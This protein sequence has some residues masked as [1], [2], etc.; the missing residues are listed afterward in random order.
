M[1]ANDIRKKFLGFFATKG[2]T[3]IPSDSLVPKNDPSVLFTTA[4]MQQF[5]RQFLGHIEGY[6]RAATSQKCLRTD[7]LEQVGQTAFHH[8]F[9]EMLGN[10]SFGD[11]FKKEAIAWAW[12]F[13]TKELKIPEDKLWATIYKNDSEAEDIWIKEIKIP[14]QRLI[15]LGDKSNFWPS[16]AKTDG[17]NGPCGPC[18]EIFYDYGV[19]PQCPNTKACNPDCDCGR[20]SEVWNLVFTQFNRQEGG[21]LDPLPSKNIDTGMGLERLTAVVQGKQN[22]FDT[23]LFLP[24]ISAV[25]EKIE[26]GL[27]APLSR[28]EKNII[29]DHIRAIVFAINDG[30]IPSNKERGFV[31]KGLIN[32]STNLILSKGVTKPSIYKLVPAVMEVMQE[33]YP[34]LKEKARDITELIKKTEEAFITVRQQRVPELKAKIKTSSEKELGDLFFI[35]H[36][37]YGLPLSTI[38]GTAKQA[39]PQSR[40]E[41]IINEAI[42]TYNKKM[43]EQKKRSRAASK[44]TDDVFTNIGLDLSAHKTIFTGYEELHNTTKIAELFA[45]DKRNEQ[46]KKGD[47]VK[48]ILEHTPFC[49]EAGGQIGDTGLIEKDDNV[50][51]VFDTQKIDNA[52]L[53]LGTV[54]KGAFKVSDQV[55]A[56][57]NRGRRL[58]IMRNHTATHLL[59]AALRKVLGSHVQQQGSLVEENR[60]RFDFTHPQAVTNQQLM[61]IENFVNER[62]MRCLEVSKTDMSLEQAKKAGALAFFAEKYGQQVRVVA[63]NDCSKEL[64]GGT[65]L[66][67]TGEIGLFKIISESAIAQGIR[68]IEAK[69]GWGALELIKNNEEVLNNISKTLKVPTDQLV[70]RIQLQ[71]KR[72]KELE[73]NS[74]RRQFENIKNN[75]SDITDKAPSLGKTKLIAHIFKGIEMGQLRKISDLIKQKNK[76][77]IM[78]LG[79]ESIENAHL[80]ISLSDDMVK[81]GLKANEIIKTVAPIIDGS[82]GGRPQLAQ[83]GSKE[84]KNL[85]QAIKEATKLVKDK[86]TA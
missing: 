39:I 43:D 31:I 40:Q 14:A 1:T 41:P 10:F 46:V 49:P 68:R 67:W 84:P 6:T 28:T 21:Q 58:S 20:F 82:G 81:K 22:N 80:L 45:D 73:K 37:T 17:P 4:G 12:E 18:S 54:K 9:F 74:E 55:Q 32:N 11:Y 23:D 50:I 76:S 38:T 48:V 19:N 78:I 13:L 64:C 86:L 35:Y 33:P 30:V 53:H 60:L 36:D 70:N 61:E 57:V 83:A 44:I 77:V 7:D 71:A 2:H 27:P 52:I 3:V 72:I 85:Q 51:E 79:A 25:E 66:N 26:K 16:N 24:I 34:E 59:Q 5:K 69:T 75:I 29:T 42:K 15:K 62:I 65:H 8:T 47:Q 56:Q 63:I